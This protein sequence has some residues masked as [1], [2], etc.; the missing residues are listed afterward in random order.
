MSHYDYARPARPAL[1]AVTSAA[2]FVSTPT[3]ERDSFESLF[4]AYKSAFPAGTTVVDFTKAVL[5]ANGIPYRVANIEA[6][7]FGLSGK[8]LPYS[9][10]DNPGKYP[11]GPKNVG[12]AY[13]GAGNKIMLPD[14]PRPGVNPPPATTPTPAPV[15]PPPP[16]VVE[17]APWWKSPWVLGGSA[18]AL[19]ALVAFASSG[20]DTSAKT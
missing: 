6:W 20:D 15:P 5:A 19:V 17:Q 10:K 13:F 12:W 9:E 11:G 3:A 18:L 4:A 16:L 1:G 8:R 14:I 2:P 7:I